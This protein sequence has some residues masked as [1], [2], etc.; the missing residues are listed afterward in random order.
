MS[1]SIFLWYTVSFSRK[2]P[3]SYFSENPLNTFAK[4]FAHSGYCVFFHAF[5]GTWLFEKL[6]F[7]FQPY[8][9]SLRMLVAKLG[10]LRKC[11]VFLFLWLCETCILM[12]FRKENV[13][14]EDGEVWWHVGFSA[15]MCQQGRGHGVRLCK[16]IL[17]TPLQ[18]LC[19]PGHREGHMFTF[20]F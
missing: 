8:L 7:A 2:S 10:P 20:F 15:G 13:L 17:A 19:L 16:G 3:W 5:F 6:K 14:L 18:H 11:A 9:F 1:F 4:V 12:V